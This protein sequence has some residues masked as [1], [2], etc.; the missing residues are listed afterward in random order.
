M[1]FQCA[2]RLRRETTITAAITASSDD[3]GSGTK[4]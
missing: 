4:V 3:E 1:G 2:F